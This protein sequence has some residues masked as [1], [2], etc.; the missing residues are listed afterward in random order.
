MSKTKA[1]QNSPMRVSVICGGCGEEF[2]AKPSETKR[3]KGNYCS[4]KCYFDWRRKNRTISCEKCG[5]SFERH[6]A[7]RRYCSRECF[8]RANNDKEVFQYTTYLSN[9]GYPT[10]QSKTM[11]RAVAERVLGRPL[12]RYEVVHH[13]N[14]K[15]EDY[16]NN[17][18]IICTQSY[19]RIIHDR[20]SRKYMEEHFNG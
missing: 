1:H 2:K 15:K 5:E 8:N 17:N 14:G 4:R 10:K 9:G 19:H 11:H 13:I 18:L 3:G 16:R 7:K 20:M 6:N 12:S